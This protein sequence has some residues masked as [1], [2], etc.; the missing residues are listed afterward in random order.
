MPPGSVLRNVDLVYCMV[1]YTGCETKVRVRQTTR[2]TKV[3]QVENELNKFIITLIGMLLFFCLVVRWEYMD[4]PFAV[5][6]SDEPRISTNG[7]K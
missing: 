7:F 5:H 1:V 4:S 2:P 6:V 3:A